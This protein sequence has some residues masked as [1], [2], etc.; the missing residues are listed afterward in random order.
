MATGAPIPHHRSPFYRSRFA[1]CVYRAFFGELGRGD[2]N[3]AEAIMLR[4]V[5]K[6][7]GNGCPGRSA[8]TQ[9]SLRNLRTLDCVVVRCRHPIS[10]L[11]EIGAECA[12]VGQARLAWTAAVSGGPGSAMHHFA[13]LALHRV[14]DTRYQR[15]DS[16]IPN[17]R[18]QTAHLVPAPAFL[19]PGF[20]SLLH[21]PPL[22]GGRSAERRSGARRN[23]RG[24][25]HNAARQAP[26]EAP[27]VP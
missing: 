21:S 4:A 15:P 27:C 26:S 18:C 25:A 17:S 3:G 5:S 6:H 24:R 16:S 11:P 19:R 1:F 13:A 9:I 12:Q 20:A 7:E 8:A 22:R 10:G 14:R 23:T 2:L